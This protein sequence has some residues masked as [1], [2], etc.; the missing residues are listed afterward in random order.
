MRTMKYIFL[1]QYETNHYFNIKKKIKVNPDRQSKV[2]KPCFKPCFFPG[3][4][5]KSLTTF[6]NKE[7]NYHNPV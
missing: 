5:K 3:K 2:N 7:I 1:A 6:S 4:C